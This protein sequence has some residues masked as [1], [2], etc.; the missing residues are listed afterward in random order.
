[1]AASCE[2]S[3]CSGY[4]GCNTIQSYESRRECLKN[5]CFCDM[6]PEKKVDMTAT[7][8]PPCILCGK[9]NQC[10]T[11]KSLKGRQDCMMKNCGNS[12]LNMMDTFPPIPVEPFVYFPFTKIY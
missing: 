4:S 3:P 10:E 8:P 12:C 11:E 6:G 2:G 7:L 9:I 5:N 1:M